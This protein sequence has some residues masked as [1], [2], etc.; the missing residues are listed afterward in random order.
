[1]KIP[2]LKIKNCLI[3]SIQFEVDD[4][5]VMEFQDNLLERIREEDI[6][7]IIIDLTS[8]DIIDSFIA[9]SIADVTKMARLLGARVVIT[10]MK[11]ALAITLVELGITLGDI[12][13]A[14]NLE[15]GLARLEKMIEEIDR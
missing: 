10:G 4:R 9:K 13:T 12:K 1:M 5:T 3:A 15:R 11:P 14:L 2:I 6:R 7:G 8:V